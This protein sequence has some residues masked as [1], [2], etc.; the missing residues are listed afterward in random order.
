MSEPDLSGKKYGRLSVIGTAPKQGR[1]IMW[2]C[3]CDCGNVV[4]VRN[5]HLLKGET[6]SCGCWIAE[7]TAQRNR[8]NAK[9]IVYEIHN[10]C[11]VGK[12][13][14]GEEFY[15]D[16]EDLHK[17][18]DKAWSL[19]KKGYLRHMYR[20]ENNNTR[21]YSMH[22]YILGVVG[23]KVQVDHIDRNKMNNRKSNLRICDSFGNARNR[24]ERKN[25]TSGFTGVIYKKS[26][27]KWY[28]SFSI[29]KKR[30]YIGGFDD[31]KDAVIARYRAEQEYYGEYAPHTLQDV[32][33][34]V[35]KEKARSLIDEA[36]I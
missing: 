14:S 27:N 21:S 8:E 24:G 25:N 31:F 9:K 12:F 32:I 15:V 36:I 4:K 11:A 2:M 28:A 1:H 6:K 18:S 16:V 13:V 35:G 3:L 10:D 30:K 29:N 26:E 5:D 17:I 20:D 34:V 7:R 33:N 23:K 22:Q 19:T